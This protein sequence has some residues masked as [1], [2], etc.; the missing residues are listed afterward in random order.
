MRKMVLAAFLFAAVS[1]ASVFAFDPDELNKITFVNDTG[2]K[3]EMIFLSPG[4]SKY[5]DRT[6]SAQTTCSRTGAR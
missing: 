1:A 4:D 2:T 6:S 5:W 3:I